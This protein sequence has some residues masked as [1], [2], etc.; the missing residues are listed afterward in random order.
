LTI[1]INKLYING[2]TVTI[3]GDG[4]VV[5]VSD[6]TAR[7]LRDFRV[8]LLVVHRSGAPAPVQGVPVVHHVV[9]RVR[10]VLRA[11]RV[12]PERRQSSHVGRSGFQLVVEMRLRVESG[13]RLQLR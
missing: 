12:G 5:A 8:A 6:E 4:S 11:V 7:G 13:K 1:N 10:V 3:R 9:L 2:V